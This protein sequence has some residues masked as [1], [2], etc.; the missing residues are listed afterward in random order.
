LRDGDTLQEVGTH[1]DDMQ[2]VTANDV[3]A[4]RNISTTWANRG[5]TIANGDQ[6]YSCS[7][8]TGAGG[9]LQFRQ[10]KLVNLWDTAHSSVGNLKAQPAQLEYPSQL[11]ASGFLIG[12]LVV[13][14]LCTI[15]ILA[16]RRKRTC[17]PQVL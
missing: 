9:Y 14:S 16:L 7:V 15:T 4:N 3:N 13:V 10:G 11:L 1:F 8:N 5:L 6:F 17:V 2:L 12:Y